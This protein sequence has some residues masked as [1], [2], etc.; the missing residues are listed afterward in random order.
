MEASLFMHLKSH[1][2]QAVR[3][4]Q[5]VV[6]AV[7]TLNTRRSAVDDSRELSAEFR[8]AAFEQALLRL[9]SGEP[10]RVS[11]RFLRRLEPSHFAKVGSDGKLWLGGPGGSRPRAFCRRCS[12]RFAPEITG[13]ADFFHP[14]MNPS[15]FKCL[16][17]RGLSVGEAGFDAAF[18]E[19]PT[20]AAGLNQQEFDAPSA[21]AV[22]DGC[23][24]LA[25]LPQT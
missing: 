6:G 4:I 22:T 19:N 3:V 20:S 8:G 10:S 2:L 18:G 9:F 5:S 7:Q 23:D 24:L 14:A 25:S 1:S 21:D 11:I 17:R 16:E 12:F 15:L 13:E